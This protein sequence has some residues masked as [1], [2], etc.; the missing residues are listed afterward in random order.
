[1]NI[2]SVS[3]LLLRPTVA[4]EVVSA[5]TGGQ[6]RLVQLSGGDVIKR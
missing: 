6:C 5:N 2:M 1:M 4:N 3:F